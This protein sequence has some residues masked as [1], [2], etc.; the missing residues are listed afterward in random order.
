MQSYLAARIVE[1]CDRFDRIFIIFDTDKLSSARYTVS[2]AHN[3]SFGLFT[4]ITESPF[5][6][7]KYWKKNS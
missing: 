2:R 4:S 3:E 7:T 1:S 6:Q 5:I